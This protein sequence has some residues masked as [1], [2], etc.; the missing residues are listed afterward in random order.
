MSFV[1]SSLILLILFLVSCENK[2]EMEENNKVHRMQ[3]G[4]GGM[5]GNRRR[6]QVRK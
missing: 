4:G 5:G 3:R 2:M 6:R 1:K